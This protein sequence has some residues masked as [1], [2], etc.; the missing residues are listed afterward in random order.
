MDFWKEI[1]NS[2]TLPSGLTMNS[3]GKISGISTI[4]GDSEF[5][6]IA[7]D[8][9]SVSAT[10]SVSVLVLP[11]SIDATISKVVFGLN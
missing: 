6:V 10:Q 7:T 11:P 4:L 9:A 5:S 2:G 8:S 3:E 1:L